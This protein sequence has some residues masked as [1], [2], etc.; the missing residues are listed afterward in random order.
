MSRR[1]RRIPRPVISDP[2]SLLR[3]VSP[4]RSRGVMLAFLTALDE[5]ARGK[6]PGVEEWRSLADCVNTLET[7]A[8]TNDIFG[9]GV[10]PA[11]NA[12]IEAMATAAK[13][14][15][16]GHGMRL[17]GPGMEE[18]RTVI[19]IYGLCLKLLTERQMALAQQRTQARMR[20][21]LR[22]GESEQVIAL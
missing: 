22:A 9:E 11:V 4:E 5:I 14:Y 19:E 7:L 13:R 2:L 20:V 18:L 17:D 1:P 21:L 3:P 8:L 12:A 15:R 6:H 10:M 16:A